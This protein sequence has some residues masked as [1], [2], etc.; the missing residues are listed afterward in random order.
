MNDIQLKLRI[1][2]IK[3]EMLYL[4]MKSLKENKYMLIEELRYLNQEYLKLIVRLQKNNPSYNNGK[5]NPYKNCYFYALDLPV[6]FAYRLDYKVILDEISRTDLGGISRPEDLYR[7]YIPKT[8]KEVLDYLYSDLDILQI[9]AYDSGINIP[10]KHDGYKIAVF[11][12]SGSD[13]DYHFIRQN[14]DGSWSSKVGYKD[15]VIKMADPLD[16]LNDNIYNEITS[17]E[18]IKTLELVKPSIKR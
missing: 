5:C 12:E 14:T 18:L 6:P 16:Y 8:E 9:K 2:N 17:Y 7:V 11:M 3:K 4:I 15:C 13:H 1:I 10:N